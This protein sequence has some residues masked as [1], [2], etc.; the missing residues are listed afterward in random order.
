[1]HSIQWYISSIGDTVIVRVRNYYDIFQLGIE[2]IGSLVS[3]STR[4]HLSLKQVVNQ[5][6]FT[7][8]DALLI[9]GLIALCCGVIIS[10]QAMTTM[11]KFGAS[12]Y[13]GSV[14]VIRV[15]RELGP[16]LTALIVAGRSGAALAA[17]I[18]NMR[19]TKELAAL[20]VMGISPIQFINK[21][22]NR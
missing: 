1:M 2:T 8:V 12:G 10:V 21:R 13:F 5:I 20:T 7:G 6:L 9:V 17:Y 16:F 14:M 11:P 4:K 22:Y 19:V 18:G 3:D 15:V